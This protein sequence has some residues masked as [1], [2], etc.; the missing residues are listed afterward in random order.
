MYA[1]VF[2]RI[3]GGEKMKIV[4][5]KTGFRLAGFIIF[6]LFC[7]LLAGPVNARAESYE[8]LF[9]CFIDLPGWEGEEPEGM[10]VEQA[11]MKMIN[12]KRAY[13][14]GDKE[15]TAVIMIGNQ[16]GTGAITLKGMAD[17]ETDEQK[18]TVKTIKG[19]LTQTVYDK[20]DRS[21]TVTVIILPR[22]KLGAIFTLSFEGLTEKE[23]IKVAKRFDWN[24]IREKAE[25]FE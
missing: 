10:K 11:G 17:I 16:V 22:E 3:V 5:R 2:R 21:G 24:L 25:S 9:P 7:F 18:V 1:Y 23:A 6:A 15:I 8:T 12:A 4:P 19:F 14:K 20:T 13:T